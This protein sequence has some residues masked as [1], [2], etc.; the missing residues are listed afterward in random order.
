MLGNIDNISDISTSS[1]I[2]TYLKKEFYE[3]KPESI[4][5]INNFSSK[6]LD[7]E[8]MLGKINQDL[9]AE[10]GYSASITKLINLSNC[11]LGLLQLQT[12]YYSKGEIPEK[13]K[14]P[15]SITGEEELYRL[16]DKTLSSSATSVTFLNNGLVD[17]EE[18]LNQ[19]TTQNFDYP[20]KN[21]GY[22]EDD[23]KV[24]V[25]IEYLLSVEQIQQT[26]NKSQEILQKIIKT[27]MSERDKIK[28]IHDYIINTTRYDER[29][30]ILGKIPD[31]SYTSYGV[32]IKNLGVCQ[33]YA[34]AF[35]ALAK[36]AGINSLSIAGKGKKTDHAWNMVKIG[37][38]ELYV[39]CTWDDPVS[40]LGRNYLVYDYFMLSKE[41]MLLDHS[42]NLEKYPERFINNCAR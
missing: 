15:D 12:N 19:F 39:D 27:P 42:W 21:I 3:K 5:R 17:Y 23:N 33:G 18:L 38:Q 8:K 11:K 2:S 20:I 41:K 24:T 9:L 16:M 1:E 25:Y 35:N 26:R 31:D 13:S 29:S 6:N 30:Y 40:S 7:I 10:K 22:T 28:A 14:F 36:L 4:L 34:A 32:F 37:P